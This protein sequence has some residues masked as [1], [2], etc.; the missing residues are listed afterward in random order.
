MN[1][2]QEMVQR[3]MYARKAAGTAAVRIAGVPPARP[4]GDPVLCAVDVARISD[5]RIR[6]PLSD[7]ETVHS[8]K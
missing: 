5:P 1:T 7:R 8:K 6:L 3:W 2:F 4:T